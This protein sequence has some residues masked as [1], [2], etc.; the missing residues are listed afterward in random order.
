MPCWVFAPPHP[1]PL[2]FSK[3][4]RCRL[5]CKETT[6]WDA[7]AADLM[8]GDQLFGFEGT[9]GLREAFMGPFMIE[10]S[11]LPEKMEIFQQEQAVS[12]FLFTIDGLLFA[13]DSS[14]SRS[15]ICFMSTIASLSL[16]ESQHNPART[17]CSHKS[18]PQNVAA[19]GAEGYLQTSPD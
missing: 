17:S 18:V 6:A 19:C 10:V 4:E 3:S 2:F 13:G 15:V 11:D 1:V 8:V 9:H 5:D 16:I 7:Y 14:P 12:R